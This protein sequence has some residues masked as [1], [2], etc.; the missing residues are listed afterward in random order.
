MRRLRSGAQEMFEEEVPVDDGSDGC[1]FFDYGVDGA[2]S[3]RIAIPQRRQVEFVER[4]QGRE[5]RIGRCRPFLA[6]DFDAA[7]VGFAEQTKG[8]GTA[9]E[10][11]RMF[12]KQ[13]KRCRPVKSSAAEQIVERK[14]GVFMG[15]RG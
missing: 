7:E 13:L 14:A 2:Y 5:A 1:H 6:N 10:Q 9:T 15:S 4:A 11:M 3:L 12:L 8:A